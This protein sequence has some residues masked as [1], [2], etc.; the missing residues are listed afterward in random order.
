MAANFSTAWYFSGQSVI[1]SYQNCN[2]KLEIFHMDNRW[3]WK[4]SH[5]SKGIISHS[6]SSWNLG[7]DLIGSQGFVYDGQSG[8]C[9][10]YKQNIVKRPKFD[11]IGSYISFGISKIQ[12]SL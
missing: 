1:I 8:S 4:M 2:L 5:N 12:Y 6:S 10:D 3:K 9:R 7:S 11:V